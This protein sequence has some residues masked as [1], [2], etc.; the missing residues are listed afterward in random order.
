MSMAAK[1]LGQYVKAR[2]NSFRFCFFSRFTFKKSRIFCNIVNINEEDTI[3]IKRIFSLT[4]F[5]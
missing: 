4:K 3:K 1:V 5:N 2:R